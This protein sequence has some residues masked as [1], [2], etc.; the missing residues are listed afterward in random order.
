MQT[1]FISCVIAYDNRQPLPDDVA[2]AL[3]NLL[4]G[5][6][7]NALA[8]SV[9]NLV[10]AS[11]TAPSAGTNSVNIQITSQDGTTDDEI[12]AWV[13]QAILKLNL[14]TSPQA[15]ISAVQVTSPTTAILTVDTTVVFQVGAL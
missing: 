14:W 6:G 9:R 5:N 8:V 10:T 13:T 15:T 11:M 3:I 12:I 7:F 1:N 4:N 2:N